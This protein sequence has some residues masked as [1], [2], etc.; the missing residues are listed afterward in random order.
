M[1]SEEL[2]LRA[3]QRLCAGQ[4]VRGFDGGNGFS[5]IDFR[6]ATGVNPWLLNQESI[7]TGLP[8]SISD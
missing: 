4:S 1:R 5:P 7:I 2:A 3:P 8:F 6:Q